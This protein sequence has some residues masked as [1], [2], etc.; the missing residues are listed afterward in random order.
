VAPAS[1]LWRSHS[2]AINSR[3]DGDASRYHHHIA[4]LRIV[5]RRSGVVCIICATGCRRLYLSHVRSRWIPQA[6][7]VDENR[8]RSIS[9][10]QIVLEHID[11]EG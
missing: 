1:L 3:S 6:K 8:C 7:N 4:P 2:Q 10:L 5:E 9:P 11:V